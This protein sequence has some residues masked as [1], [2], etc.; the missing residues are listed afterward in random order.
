MT[1]TSSGTDLAAGIRAE[2]AAAAAHLTAA[3]TPPRLAV[4]VT[5]ADESSAWYVRSITRAAEKTG[6]ACSVVDLGETATPERIRAEPA[7]L[8][9]D[10]AVYGIILQTP[11][12]ADAV[13]PV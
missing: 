4:V 12:P 13:G 6:I 11:L 9:A 7:A 8:S 5:T 10:P 2:L 3:G 1:A